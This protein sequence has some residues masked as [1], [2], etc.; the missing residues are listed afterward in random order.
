LALL[1]LSARENPFFP[2]QNTQPP[3][4][5]TNEVEKP[6]NFQDATTKLPSSARIIESIEF[7]YINL[8]GSIAKQVVHLHRSIDWHKPFFI[9]Q[10][11]LA[12]KTILPTNK[13]TKLTPKLVG[14]LK[15]IRFETLKETLFI[16]TKDPILRNFKLIKPDRIVLDFQRDASF[17]SYKYKASTPFETIR[18]GNHNGYY[19]VVIELDGHY[20]YKLEKTPNG[21]K[22]ILR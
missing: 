3:A 18:I 7:T 21:Y 10:E 6:P 8:D 14:K 20:M 17:R 1:P 5:T 12:Q 22:V 2:A 19:R 9:T 11:P 16:T 13:Q 4:Y 15:F